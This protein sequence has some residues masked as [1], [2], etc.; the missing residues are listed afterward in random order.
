MVAETVLMLARA[1][2][3]RS[4]TLSGFAAWM[5]ITVGDTRPE[6]WRVLVGSLLRKVE[7]GSAPGS[8]MST[9]GG[10]LRQRTAE[11]L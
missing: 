8:P 4:D 9:S 1:E 2:R 11:V 5:V 10:R 3:R 7:Q 6:A